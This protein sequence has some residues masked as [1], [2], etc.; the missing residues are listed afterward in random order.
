MLKYRF[1]LNCISLILLWNLFFLRCQGILKQEDEL[2]KSDVKARLNTL[3]QFVPE[4]HYKWYMYWKEDNVR[5]QSVLEGLQYGKMHWITVAF[6]D[7]ISLSFDKSNPC[8]ALYPNKLSLCKFEN[9]TKPICS[10][11]GLCIHMIAMPF[12]NWDIMHCAKTAKLGRRAIQVL[13]SKDDL[14]CEVFLDKNFNTI[15]QVKMWDSAS[16]FNAGFTLKHLKKFKAGWGI[17]V[18]EFTLNHRKTS[19]FVENIVTLD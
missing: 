13:L 8:I 18:A 15:L 16:K 7:K 10:L 11:P 3:Q 6:S 9:F 5:K 2:L 19:L 14:Y 4:K 1:I 12:L 17:R